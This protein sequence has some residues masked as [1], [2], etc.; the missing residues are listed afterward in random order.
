MKIIAPGQHGFRWVLANEDTRLEHIRKKYG[1]YS[2]P[3]SLPLFYIHDFKGMIKDILYAKGS[4]LLVQKAGAPVRYELYRE[5][6]IADC[7]DKDPIRI[8][9][10]FKL[11]PDQKNWVCHERNGALYF[12]NHT[13]KESLENLVEHKIPVYHV[14]AF[15]IERQMFK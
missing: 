9:H 2:I 10:K 7:L 11:Q 4:F 13:Y 15:P 6:T 12:T 3:I 8:T 5:A 1:I 14:D